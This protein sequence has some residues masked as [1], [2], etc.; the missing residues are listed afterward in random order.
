[1][2]TVFRE[3]VCHLGSAFLSPQEDTDQTF[4]VARI[5]G[6]LRR[7]HELVSGAI[8]GAFREPVLFK[9]SHILRP[10]L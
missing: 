10:P 5:P 3:A 9:D 4:G 8:F 1:M 2:A 7:V 6:R